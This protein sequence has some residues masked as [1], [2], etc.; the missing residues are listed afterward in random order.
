MRGLR[1]SSKER[2]SSRRVRRVRGRQRHLRGLRRRAQQRQEA[3]Q[4][5]HLRRQR[6]DLLKPFRLNRPRKRMHAAARV[7]LVERAIKSHDIFFFL[8]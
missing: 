2:E 1:W 6:P 7:V 4:L 5:R 3:R 8:F